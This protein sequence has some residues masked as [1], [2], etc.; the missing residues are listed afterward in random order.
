MRLCMAYQN[1]FVRLIMFCMYLSKLCRVIKWNRK[2]KLEACINLEFDVFN[3]PW[4]DTFGRISSHE[5]KVMQNFISKIGYLSS[6]M[7]IKS[8]Q[9][10]SSEDNDISNVIG[11][12]FICLIGYYNRLYSI[13][14]IY[15]QNKCNIQHMHK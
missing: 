9:L 3:I 13:I 10:Q 5:G 12:R 6:F 4:N 14:W 15:V 7:F 1:L 11:C 2:D 8:K